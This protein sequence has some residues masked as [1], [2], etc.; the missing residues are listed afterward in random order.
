MDAARTSAYPSLVRRTSSSPGLWPVL[1]AIVV[2]LVVADFIHHPF[3]GGAPGDAA[4]RRSDLTLWMARS[5]ADSDNAATLRLAAGY[6]G[7]ESETPDVGELEG[8]SAAALETFAPRHRRGG[9]E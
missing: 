8:G 9:P 3:I 2:A 7:K 4:P 5:E 1:L 6:L